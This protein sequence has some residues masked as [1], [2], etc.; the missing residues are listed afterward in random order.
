MPNFVSLYALNAS[1]RYLDEIGVVN[2][3]A[4]ADPLVH[5]MEA[6]LR[7]LGLAPMAAQ[8]EG[9]AS[10]ILA[11]LHENTESIHTKMESSEVHIMHHAGRL[12]MA[13]HVYNTKED[14]EKFFE[15]LKKAL[16]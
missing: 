7:E 10:G 5:Q 1:L 12:R 8:R 16:N 13:L 3:A 2:I 9:C 4:H 6:G 11:F 15:V 14:V